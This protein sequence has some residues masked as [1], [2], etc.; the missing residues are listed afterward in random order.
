M[1][2]QNLEVEVTG[3]SSTAFINLVDP[4]GELFDQARLEGDDTEASFEILG[5]YEDDLPT[6]KYELVALESLESDDPIDSTTISLDAECKITDVLWAAENPDMDWEKRS[7]AWEAHAAVVIENKG[8]IPS[9]LTELEWAG[10]PVARLQSKDAQSYYHEVRLSPGETTVYS[11]GPVYRTENSIQSLDC[12][13][14]GTESMT[15]TAITQVGPDPSFT[16]QIEYGSEQS[17]ELA[18]VEGN[19][20]GSPSDGGEN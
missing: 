5:R 17:C 8:T 1:N 20:D 18:I 9:V 12:G 14:Y 4:N 13:E 2:E 7:S 10:A 6:G 15:V 11:E 16:Q 19:P 3:E